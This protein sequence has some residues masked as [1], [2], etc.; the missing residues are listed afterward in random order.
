MSLRI[1]AATILFL[2]LLPASPQRAAE[3]AK[4]PNILFA[5]ADD[6]SYPHM[7]AYGTT[8]VKTPAFDR[9]A[10]EGI[11]F[12]NAYTPNA[13]CAPSRAAIL[14]GRNSWQLKEAANHQSF[15][16]LEFKTFPEALAEHGY[17]AGK[18]HKGWAPGVAND[19]D[20]NPRQLTGI[21]FDKRQAEPPAQAI[22]KT[23]YA[24]NFR[25]F[26]D[27]RP[28]D[29]PWC[30]W[31]GSV[32]PHRA[33]EYGAGVNKGGK[34][35]SDVDEVPEFWPDTEVIRT[36]MLDY[37]FEIEHFDRH[38][39]RMIEE[40][41]KRGELDNTLIVVTADN[42]M[43]FPRVK[44]QEY[45]LSNHLPLAMTWKSRIKNPG[46]VV[47]DYVSFIDFAPTFLEA[48]G[49]DWEESGMKPS[50]GR[51]LTD[52]FDS[53]KAGQV[54]PE[55]D[56]VLI[57]KERHDVG[58]PRDQGYPIRGIVKNGMLYL[59]NFEPDRWPAGNPETGYPNCD[60]SPTKT[61]VLESRTMAPATQYWQLSFGKRPAE[62]LYNVKDD[63]GCLRNLAGRPETA[64]TQSALAEHMMSELKQ[65]GDPRVFGQGHI[66]DEYPVAFEMWRGF[67]ERFLRGEA[68][69]P[70]WIAESD[71]EKEPID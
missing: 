29:K 43:P 60:A 47:D 55:R 67:Y 58:R 21:S 26:L 52:I 3:P 4:R 62:E 56:H 8:W 5:I 68:P 66:F 9:V 40:L 10:R 27:A 63:P 19:A 11:L 25:D 59:R 1:T 64:A 69:Q 50:P 65:Q 39:G 16:P 15:F 22:A 35:L 7:S 34:K 36:D 45:E 12:N 49:V 61:Q 44:G 57:G 23:D 24:A 32:E 53:E 17:F 51:S 46:R 38:L 14:T 13:K 18:T 6:A 30:F 41:E 2:G 42:G 28:K 70:G 33:Y 20:G 37:A 54:N 48:A 31:Y 71:I